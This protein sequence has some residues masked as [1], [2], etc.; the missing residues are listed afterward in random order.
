L[1]QID[2]SVTLETLLDVSGMSRLEALRVLFRL[3]ERGVIEL[4]DP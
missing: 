1:S 3:I 2:G 4:L